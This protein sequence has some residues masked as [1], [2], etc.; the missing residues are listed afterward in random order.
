MFQLNG[1]IAAVTGSGSGIGKAIA[2]LFAHQGAE[3]HLIDL[4]EEAITIAQEEIKTQGGKAFVQTCNVTAQR[5][6]KDLF[7]TIDRLDILVNSAGVSHIGN[8]ESTSEKD[9]D[10]LFNV[11]VKGVYNCMQAAVS[12]MKKNTR[13]F[14]ICLAKTNQFHYKNL[15]SV[16]SVL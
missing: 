11:N 12:V 9:F 4:N 8:V 5:Q 10:R 7:E 6:V 3:V 15:S 14:F 2:L 13:L 16:N 1:K